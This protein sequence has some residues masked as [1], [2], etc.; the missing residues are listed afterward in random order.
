MLLNK[1]FLNTGI[2]YKKSKKNSNC[3]S[4]N[5]C[6]LKKILFLING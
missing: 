5:K 3:F 4:Q 1:N 6:N 2:V